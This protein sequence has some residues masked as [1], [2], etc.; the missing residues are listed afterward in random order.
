MMKIEIIGPGCPFCRT[1]YK[2]VE[3]VVRENAIDA[4]IAHVKDFAVFIRYFPRTPV[5]R[6]DGQVLH[7]GKL[8]PDKRRIK[9][10]IE[11][12]A[13]HNKSV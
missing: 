13:S 2:R 8:L 12:Y 10:L 9:G 4:E 11:G 7:K 6:V 1:L 3:E 5:L